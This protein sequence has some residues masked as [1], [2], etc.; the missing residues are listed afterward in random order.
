MDYSTVALIVGLSTAAIALLGYW[1]TQYLQRRDR[2][3]SMYAD[4]MAAMQAY[5]YTPYLT[6]RR[7][8]ST[9]M[10]RATITAKITDINVNVD[11]KEKLLLMDSPAV[12]EAYG[13]L[14][15][16]TRQQVRA[17][18]DQAWQTPVISRDDQM[19]E[20]T[21]QYPYDNEAEWQSCTLAMR[22]ELTLMGSVLH[23]SRVFS[24]RLR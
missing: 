16:A 2:R 8:D 22:S 19:P 12:G 6:R 4:A 1:N 10:T 21:R 9:G 18:R 13:R 24:H 20:S 5:E 17:Y 11:H 14:L 3:G 15:A 23:P 7:A